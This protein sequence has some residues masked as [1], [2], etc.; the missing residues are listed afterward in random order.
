MDNDDNQCVE[1]L[2]LSANLFRKDF[3]VT[4]NCI[5]TFDK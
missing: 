2:G 4:H 1:N 3:L 5:V